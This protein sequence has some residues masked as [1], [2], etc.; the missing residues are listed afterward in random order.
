MPNDQVMRNQRLPS[1]LDLGN[2]IAKGWP[3][4][5]SVSLPAELAA[6]RLIPAV[7][8]LF[9]PLSGCSGRTNS[10]PERGQ[11]DT[12]ATDSVVASGSSRD[13]MFADG[14][15]EINP[16]PLEVTQRH[17]RIVAR[18]IEKSYQINGKY[19]ANVRE[20]LS[21][22]IPDPNIRPQEWWLIDGWNRPLRYVQ[23]PAGY[24]L[25]SAGEDG[26]FHSDDD[27]VDAKGL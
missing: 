12:F 15:R 13:S 5:L 26:I 1:L 2:A 22:A 24:E 17:M 25:R 8:A 6:T 4:G 7:L 3:Q 19:P 11:R 21:L 27:L 20:I 14:R 18:A 23:Q 9:I 16:T 10:H